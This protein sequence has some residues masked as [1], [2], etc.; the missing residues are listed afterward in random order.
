MPEIQSEDAFLSAIDK[1]PGG[2]GWWH[3]SGGETY[4]AL[5]KQLTEHGFTYDEAVDIL[6]S[7]YSAAADEYGD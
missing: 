6:S 4:I 2:N 7:A 5:G 3:S 1:I